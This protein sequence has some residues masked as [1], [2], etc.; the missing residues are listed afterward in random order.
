MSQTVV[1][2]ACTVSRSLVLLSV[3]LAVSG[4]RVQ[5]GSPGT[6]P[7]GASPGLDLSRARVVDLTHAYDQDTLYWPTSTERFV[8]DRLSFGPS[9]G[10]W[11]YSSNAYSS[12]EH[13]GTH[14]DAPIHFSEGGLSVDQIPVERLIAPA[15]VIDISA[16][17]AVDPDYRLQVEDVEDWEKS[18]GE[19][20]IGAAVLLHT[21]WDARWPRALDYLGDDTPGDATNLHFPSFG[22]ATGRLLV[23]QR[24]VSI[25]GVDTASIDAGSSAD[26]MVHRIAAGQQVLGLENLR[27]L[28]ELPP[29][30]AWIVAL[31]MKIADGSG[32]PVRA[33][34]L[35]SE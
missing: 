30:G 5:V 20:P 18:F 11:F 33:V 16:Q 22:E 13:G 28:G 34:A 3:L 26:F 15:I 9:E 10:G 25:L 6:E 4:C 14:L 1:E 21:G 29:R 17:C 31:P 7:S 19:I 2:S 8:L 23:E 32:G 12:P 24:R 27:G 35:L